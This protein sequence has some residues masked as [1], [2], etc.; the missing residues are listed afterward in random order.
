[1]TIIGRG[2]GLAVAMAVAVAGVAMADDAVGR[3]DRVV[4][5]VT[6]QGGG[7]TRYLSARAPIYMAET[8]QS[9]ARAR[10]E[11]TLQDDTRIT[12]GENAV[13]RVE[14]FLFAKGEKGGRLSLQV[15]DGAVRFVGGGIETNGGEIKVRTPFASVGVRGTDF[16]AGPLDGAFAVFV[17]SGAV[18]VSNA[19]RTVHLSQGDGTT[20][21]TTTSQPQDVV[22][23]GRPKIDRALAT[24]ALD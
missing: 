13:I 4:K 8:L 19:G 11:A 17:V 16:W 1:M 12:M 18:T 2:F 22:A 15:L 21:A 23:W 10:L 7:S 6:A 14:D 24:T 5:S 20:I 9:H 3:A